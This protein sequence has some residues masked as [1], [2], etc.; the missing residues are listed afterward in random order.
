MKN[1]NGMVLVGIIHSIPKGR[2]AADRH[3]LELISWG[4]ET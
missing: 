3:P 2:L 1:E 4:T